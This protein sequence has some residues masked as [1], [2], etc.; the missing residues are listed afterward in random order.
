MHTEQ[1]AERK[2]PY[3]RPR[4]TVHGDIAALTRA[5]LDLQNAE[6]LWG[7]KW[8]HGGGGHGVS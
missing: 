2:Q 7:W 1:V 5:S 4:F 8:K 6:T 3:H